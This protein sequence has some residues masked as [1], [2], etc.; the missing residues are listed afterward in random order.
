LVNGGSLLAAHYQ[1]WATYLSNYVNTLK[2]TYGIPLYA[3]SVQNEPDFTASYQSMLYTSQNFHDFILN[4]LGPTM[5]ANNPGVKI[6]MPEQAHWQFNLAA[7]TLADPAAYAHVNIV[8]AHSYF[9]SPVAQTLPAGIELWETED[10]DLGS[11]DDPSM[12]N[13]LGWAVKIHNYLTVANINAWGWWWGVDSVECTGQGLINDSNSGAPCLGTVVAKRLWA[14]GN[15]SRFVRPGYVRIGAT[16]NPITNVYVSSYKDPVS[17]K[18]AIVVVNQSTSPQSLTF[19][20]N[21]FPTAASVTPWV[22]SS[23]LNLAQQPSIPVN[24][25]TFSATIAASSVTTFVGL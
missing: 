18:F 14:T 8:A 17:G 20:L 1:D 21:G 7:A 16:A 13:A 9:N 12:S 25:N 6:M 4:N 10:S 2:N 22:T 24:G 11:P 15:F 23:S 5:R 19:T 3:L